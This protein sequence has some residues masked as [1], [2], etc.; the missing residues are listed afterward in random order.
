MTGILTVLGC[1]GS[2]G[3]PKIGNDWGKCDPAEPRNQRSRASVIIQNGE[4]KIVIDT[5]ADFRMQMNRENIGGVSAVFYTHSHSDHIS[6]MDDLRPLRDK[7]KSVIPI[8]GTR[9]TIEYL[10]SRFDYMFRDIP[11][12]YPTVVVPHIWEAHDLNKKKVFGST[13]YVAF[14][15]DHQGL[16]SL[17]FRFGDIAYSTDMVNLDDRAIDTLQGV[18]TWVADGNNLFSDSMGPHA[19]LER[20]QELNERIG[21]ETIYVTHLKNNLDYNFVNENLPKGYRCC[22][23]GLKIQFDGTVLNDHA[24]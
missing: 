12:Y 24:R 3:V 16:V 15:Q 9:E 20:L 14:E 4:D 13:E 1:G 8:F 11:P 10:Q 21:V 7:N 18:K 19:S 2:S 22:F 17:G 6:G 5:G 23:D